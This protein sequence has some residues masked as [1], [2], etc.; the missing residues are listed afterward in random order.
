MSTLDTIKDML[1]RGETS[2]DK[3]RNG[4]YRYVFCP[5]CG[6]PIP[7]RFYVLT[8]SDEAELGV[9]SPDHTGMG[10][11]CL[12]CDNEGVI[13]HTNDFPEASEEK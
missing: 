9:R 11:D 1:N 6:T 2:V 8:S 10:F 12:N 13:Y 4:E 7:Q 5:D 3:A